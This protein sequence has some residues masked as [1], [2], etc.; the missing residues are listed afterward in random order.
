MAQ[1]VFEILLKNPLSSELK[2]KLQAAE[3]VKK[4]NEE[5]LLCQPSNLPAVT[6]FLHENAQTY[7]IIGSPNAL[8]V[9]FEFFR[10]TMGWPEKT[11]KGLARIIPVDDD[12]L[13]VDSSVSGIDNGDWQLNIH[14]YGDLS[15]GVESTGN[16]FLKLGNVNVKDG[17]GTWTGNVKAK[18]WEL[19]GKAMCL[20]KGKDSVCGILA[21]SAGAFE[22]K[23]RVCACSGR[24]IWEEE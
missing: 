15:S 21:R 17:K 9:M 10:G 1:N 2:K 6:K 23:K 16:V 11:S 3:Y 13:F 5:F 14:E 18:T 7:R 12:N 8:V 24:T 19:V 20:T 4:D 22:N